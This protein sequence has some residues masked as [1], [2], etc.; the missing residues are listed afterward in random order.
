[1]SPLPRTGGAPGARSAYLEQRPRE[2]QSVSRMTEPDEAN[3]EQAT[4][5]ADSSA[6]AAMQAGDESAFTALAERYRRQLHVHCYRMLGSVAD[7]EDLVQETFLRAWR[8]RSGFEERSLF[9]TWLYRIATNACLN[10][11]ERGPRR[12]MPQ[13]VAP[14]VTVATDASEARSEPPWNLD[15]PWLQPYPD[16]WLEPIASSETRPDVVLAEREAIQLAFIAA[17]QHLPGRQRAVL[18]LRDV[19]GWSAKETAALLEITVQSANGALQR[20]RETL[21]TRNAIG[22]DHVAPELTAIERT[23]LQRFVEAWERKDADALTALLRADARWAMPP[24]PLWFDGRDAI[25][26]LFHLF[27][28]ERLGEIRMVSTTANRQPAAATYLRPNGT[29]TFRLTGLA[30]LRIEGSAIAE[31]VTFSP[32]LLSAFR[33]PPTLDQ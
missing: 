17:L 13:D 31:I 5:D 20:A 21:R 2:C 1:M 16:D 25:A 9:R 22:R 14:A 32:A 8:G 29:A 11:I 28:M 15:I 23:L 19:L 33:L 7:A 27:P 12:V 24:A 3:D 10:A 6:V 18:I 26:R 30:V 4:G